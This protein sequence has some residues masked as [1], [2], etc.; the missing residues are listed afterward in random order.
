MFSSGQIVFA[1]LFIIGFTIIMVLSYRK[2]K[3]LHRK[4]YKGVKWV[5][6]AFVIFVILLFVLKFL[7]KN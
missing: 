1:V 4:N 3:K 2:D 6:I 5:A 7:L